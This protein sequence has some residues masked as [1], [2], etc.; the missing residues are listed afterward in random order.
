MCTQDKWE[1]AQQYIA[2]LQHVQETTN[3][4]DFKELESIRGFLI[5]V[6][7]TYPAFTPYLKGVHLTLHSWRPNRDDEGWKMVHALHYHKNE[8]PLPTSPT[9]PRCGAC[10]C[11]SHSV[12]SCIHP[13]CIDSLGRS[14]KC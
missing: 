12:S 11:L 8:Y 4:F 14:P 9:Q 13:R 6:I 1:K 2:R 5:Y 10:Q 7:C 3:S